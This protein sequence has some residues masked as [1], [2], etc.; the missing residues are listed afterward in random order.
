MYSFLIL[1]V[2][3]TTQVFADTGTHLHHLGTVEIW[4][5]W[6][7][8]AADD[9]EHACGEVVS[10]FNQ[11]NKPVRI[12]GNLESDEAP[13]PPAVASKEETHQVGYKCRIHVSQE[14]PN[15]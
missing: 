12:V 3:S 11:R 8:I 2:L 14:E 9:A 10:V 6:Y 1:I 5:G 13:A 4:S 7:D 15:F